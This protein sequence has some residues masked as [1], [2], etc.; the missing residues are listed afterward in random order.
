MAK[1]TPCPCPQCEYDVLGVTDTRCPECGR[2][3]RGWSASAERVTLLG[4]AALYDFLSGTVVLMYFNFVLTFGAIVVGVFAIA[5]H[6]LAGLAVGG[7]YLYLVA[8]LG[9]GYGRSCCVADGRV[10]TTRQRVRW[11]IYSLVAAV[12]P[13]VALFVLVLILL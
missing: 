8:K 13:F 6:P 11:V 5:L 2:S 12:F 3:L 7:V 4:S 10:F 1:H 9:L